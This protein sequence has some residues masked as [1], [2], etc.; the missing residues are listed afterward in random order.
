MFHIAEITLATK[1][2]TLSDVSEILA[3]IA[4]ARPG[5]IAAY[6]VAAPPPPSVTSSEALTDMLEEEE[7]PEELPL[8]AAAAA[9]A[10]KETMRPLHA[11]RTSAVDVLTSR[12]RKHVYL[13]PE[14]YVAAGG[15]PRTMKSRDSAIRGLGEDLLKWREALAAAPTINKKTCIARYVK[16]WTPFTNGMTETD[17][18]DA[19]KHLHD[20]GEEAKKTTTGLKSANDYEAIYAKIDAVR[21][22]KDKNP[23]HVFGFILPPRRAGDLQFL[24]FCDTPDDIA[25]LPAKCNYYVKSTKLLVFKVFKTAGKH[26]EQRYNLAKPLH[27]I[28]ASAEQ[29]AEA[30]ALLDTM[31]PGEKLFVGKNVSVPFNRAFGVTVSDIRHYYV[32][33]IKAGASKAAKATL[34]DWLAH[35]ATT[36]EVCYDTKVSTMSSDDDE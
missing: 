17:V 12:M 29:Q 27:R 13:S 15:P 5:L 30:I 23:T 35:D 26:K 2:A 33:K 18:I 21:E 19:T 1:V 28:L 16:M 4:E 7:E 25:K 9:A 36:S 20:L 22:L 11:A 6:K 10:P 31:K 3:A 24:E 8:P 32:T 34:C 14:W